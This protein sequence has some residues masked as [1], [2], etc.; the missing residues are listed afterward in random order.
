MPVDGD[1]EVGQR[2][3]C[4]GKRRHRFASE[5]EWRIATDA[6]GGDGSVAFRVPF[7]RC[8]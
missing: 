1:D 6:S 7:P 2:S 4:V 5:R 3:R 8:C